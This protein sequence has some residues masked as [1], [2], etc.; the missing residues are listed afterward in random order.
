MADADVFVRVSPRDHRYLELSDGRPYVPI[1][2][3][4]VGSPK[5]EAFEA[6]LDRMVAH[7]LNYCRIWLN[8]GSFLIESPRSG[9]VDEDAARDLDRFLALAHERGIRVKLCLEYFRNIRAQKKDWA[10]KTLHHQAHGG[11]FAEVDGVDGTAMK[12]TEGILLHDVIWAPFMSGAAGTG[13]IW[14]W[15]HYVQA[16]D[17]WWQFDRFAE[18]TAGIDPPAEAF[19]PLM[20]EHPRLRVYVL[21]GARTVLIWCRDR[22]NDWAAELRDGVPPE[23]LTGVHLDLAAPVWHWQRRPRPDLVP[24]LVPGR[25]WTARAYDPW[26]NAWTR[27]AVDDAPLALPP[28]RRSIVLR[29]ETGPRRESAPTLTCKPSSAQLAEVAPQ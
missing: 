15:D 29:L 14:H 19:E 25:R 6:T 26:T 10:D 8:H 16:N 5:P 21:R 7:R 27:V 11:A 2:L 24:L 13:Q 20:L 22:A 12:D 1:G 9:A 18:A 17:L 28:F 4:L 23:L 3:N